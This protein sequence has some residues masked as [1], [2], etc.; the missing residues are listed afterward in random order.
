MGT[1]SATKST[2]SYRPRP[3]GLRPTGLV[4][5]GSVGREPAWVES[6][7]VNPDSF[8]CFTTSTSACMEVSAR[9]GKWSREGGEPARL[10]WGWGWV[11]GG[12]RV[13]LWSFCLSQPLDNFGKVFKQICRF[14]L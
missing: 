10:Q 13:H 4:S 6:R 14:S 2:F 8:W 12:T 11:S 1:K 7:N 9:K 5:S 3:S